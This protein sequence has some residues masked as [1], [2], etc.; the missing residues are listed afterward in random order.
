AL[1]AAALG[2]PLAVDPGEHLVEADAPGRS[3]WSTTVVVPPGGGEIV[4][5][6][7]SLA[8]VLAPP[9]TPPPEPVVTPE[10]VAGP[11]LRL[12][13]FAVGGGGVVVLGVGA[14]FGAM[15]LADASAAE[16]D[17]A[18]CPRRR[19]TD[20]GEDAIAD[21]E[22]KAWVSNVAIGLGAAAIVTGGVLLGLSVLD[23]EPPTRG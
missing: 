5:E 8:E 15:T 20:A 12:I 22:A 10:P 16:D 14:I 17:P 21:A 6:V 3:R 1:G 11:D 19:C 2:V 18:L 23:D 9:P 7:P 13:G 4:V